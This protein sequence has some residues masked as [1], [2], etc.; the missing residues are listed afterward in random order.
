M[1]L[2]LVR[3]WKDEDYRDSLTEDEKKQLAENPAGAIELTDT[4]L[5]MVDGAATPTTIT[6]S[7]TVGVLLSLLT[8]SQASACCQPPP[9][10]TTAV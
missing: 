8:C 9:P 6:T 5:G 3:F 7:F 1:K 2:D 10:A 4:E